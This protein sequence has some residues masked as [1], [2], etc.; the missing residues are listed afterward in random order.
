[1]TLTQRPRP[2][3]R[4]AGVSPMDLADPGRSFTNPWPA[5]QEAIHQA[6]PASASLY[7]EDLVDPG[8]RIGEGF[9]RCLLA[10]DQTGGKLAS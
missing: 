7:S 10:H 8:F 9:L 6:E 5:F 2:A 1:M 4:I 3:V